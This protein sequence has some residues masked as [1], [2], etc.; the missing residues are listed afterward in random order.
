MT[1]V[2]AFTDGVDTWLGSDT[3]GVSN[4]GTPVPCG[5]K[6][7]IHNGWAFGH[8]GDAIGADAIQDRKED[9]FGRVA[10]TPRN[11]VNRI[12]LIWEEYGLKRVFKDGGAAG[13]WDNG[14]ILA[15]AGQLW[16][17]DGCGSIAEVLLGFWARGG[18][19]AEA[20]GAAFG[21]RWGM[22]RAGIATWLPTSLIDC[23]LEAAH[24]L[25]VNIRGQWQGKLT[26][27]GEDTLK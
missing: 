15:R 16:D 9:I 25:D 7:I 17:V 18:A 6:W 13:S 27:P 11:I 8:T 23:A 24:A 22:A 1:V 20:N 5:P 10:L 3:I 2:V 4:H 19:S 14:G 26:A 12:H 21:F